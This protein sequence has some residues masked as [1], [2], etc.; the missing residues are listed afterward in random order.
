MSANVFTCCF[1]CR[2]DCFV[3]ITISV[4]DRLVWKRFLSFNFFSVRCVC[5]CWW[6]LL[7]CNFFSI[8]FTN[9]IYT[10]ILFVSNSKMHLYFP[11]VIF[12]SFY[13]YL[14]CS[15]HNNYRYGP[16]KIPCHN[17][18]GGGG[19]N[20]EWLIQN[21]TWPHVVFNFCV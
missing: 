13:W 10:Y 7:F 2:Q 17:Y 12:L 8:L 11:L 18:M 9:H 16:P 1:C 6:L 21:D 14:F 3:S 4:Q 5:Y 20:K 19:H 15:K